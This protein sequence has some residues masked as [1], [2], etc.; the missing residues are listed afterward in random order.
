MFRCDRGCLHSSWRTCSLRA[1][2]L[3]VRANFRESFRK[4]NKNTLGNGKLVDKLRYQPT[5][6]RTRFEQGLLEGRTLFR[7]FGS[8]PGRF[9]AP[10]QTNFVHRPKQKWKEHNNLAH[11][12]HGKGGKLNLVGEMQNRLAATASHGSGN[13]GLVVV[14]N[15]AA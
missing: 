5:S 8:H 2:Y 13:P 6:E 7:T 9:Q 3:C 1:K 15:G 14:R 10:T 12:N 4:L 11:T